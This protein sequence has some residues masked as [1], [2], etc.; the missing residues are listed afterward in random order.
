MDLQNITPTESLIDLSE[1]LPKNALKNVSNSMV[2]K[3]NQI[4]DG[5]ENDIALIRDNLI[6]LNSILSEGKYSV[7]DYIHAVCFVSYKL[8]GLTDKE[9]YTKVFPERIKRYE[10]KGMSSKDIASNIASYRKGRL[11]TKLFSQSLVPSWILNQD[12]YQ[13]AL[14]VT[15]DLMLT[16]KSDTVRQKAAETLINHLQKPEINDTPLININTTNSGIDELKNLLTSLA[17]KQTELINSG[18][19]AK[20]IIEMDLVQK[21]ENS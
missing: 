3:L 1:C 13:K 8:V 17:H 15:Y 21:N 19:K 18:V 6:S 11:I 9:A 4:L 5:N 12:Y 14:N 7:S 2:S 16:S 10:D 20:D